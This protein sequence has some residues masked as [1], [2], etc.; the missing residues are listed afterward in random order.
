MG[1]EWKTGETPDEGKDLI[2]ESSD[3]CGYVIGEYHADEFITFTHEGWESIE[4]VI[5][6][7][8]IED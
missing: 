1:I 3:R 2:I 5:R 4:D 6:W 8:Y 7:A